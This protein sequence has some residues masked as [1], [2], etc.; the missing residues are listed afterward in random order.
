M[1]FVVVY[2][3]CVLYPASVRDLLLRIAS[4]GLVR[5]R[6]SEQILDECFRSILEPY[7]IEAKH[8]DDFVIDAEI[9]EFGAISGDAAR[10]DGCDRPRPLAAN[11]ACRQ[12]SGGDD[13]CLCLG[14]EQ[15]QTSGAG[16]PP[17]SDSPTR[18]TIGQ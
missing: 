11:R 15:R 14:G 10:H 2:D 8:P 4:K 18:C 13:S 3:A 5:A 17:A 16:G 1:A 9:A 12:A 6:W 7:G